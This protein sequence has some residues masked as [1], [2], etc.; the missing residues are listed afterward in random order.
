MK[1]LA[2]CQES[3]LAMPRKRL[4]QRVIKPQPSGLADFVVNG[5]RSDALPNI[6]YWKGRSY[7]GDDALRAALVARA[8]FHVGDPVA[9]TE[10]WRIA[11]ARGFYPLVLADRQIRIEYKADGTT[12]DWIPYEDRYHMALRAHVMTPKSWHSSYFMF[13]EFSR[14]HRTV[15]SVVA[16]RVQDMTIDDL[17]AEGWDVQKSEPW[18]GR[19]TGE[20]ARAW[21]AALWDRLNAERGYPW[22]SNPWTYGIGWEK[23]GVEAPEP[24]EQQEDRQE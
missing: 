20:D 11:D 4:T 18:L 8:P 17:V 16:H 24:H 2:L 1:R 14:F 10:T 6:W 22:V 5:E 7:T 12:G 19:T 3:V 23:T 9:L 15:S 13:P 21:Y